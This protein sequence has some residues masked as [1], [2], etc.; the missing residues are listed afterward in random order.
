MSASI[1]FFNH[2]LSVAG[3]WVYVCGGAGELKE[4]IVIKNT[5]V[6]SEVERAEEFSAIVIG[7]I[8]TYVCVKEV[9]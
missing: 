2:H 5:K 3:V 6:A 1:Q 8:H 7:A 4:I 9:P